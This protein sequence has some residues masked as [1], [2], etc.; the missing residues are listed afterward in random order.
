[1]KS[2]NKKKEKNSFKFNA[3]TQHVLKLPSSLY[4]EEKVNLII[5]MH[6]KKQ[7]ACDVFLMT[8][9]QMFVMTQLFPCPR[10]ELLSLIKC[11]LQH[12]A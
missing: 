4:P 2:P 9:M 3:R 5:F 6:R 1:M 12:L 11:Y 8:T 7:V 10:M